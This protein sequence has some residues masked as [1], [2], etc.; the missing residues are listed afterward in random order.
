M[1][2]TLVSTMVALA[3]PVFAASASP[4]WN[5]TL[6]TT[7]WTSLAASPHDFT[8]SNPDPTYAAIAAT[9]KCE[10]CHHPHEAIGAAY[11][12]LWNHS[13][14]SGA[15]AYTM[16][17]TT[18]AGNDPTNN[19]VGNASLR[20]LGCHDGTLPID[21][22]GGSAGTPTLTVGLEKFSNLA[23]VT[24]DLTDDHPVGYNIPL[25]TAGWQANLT[26]ASATAYSGDV[27]CAS[28][29]DPHGTTYGVKFLRAAD[30][31][32]DCHDK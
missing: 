27:E 18:I 13:L 28:C 21:A 25:G 16:Y 19:A 6:S 9:N 23:D 24:T 30:F 32:T 17:G 14:N 1:K 31:C 15:N 4:L 12:P 5:A 10:S 3:M 20:C 26:G 29:H 7:P 2:R 22:Y 8:A 11:G